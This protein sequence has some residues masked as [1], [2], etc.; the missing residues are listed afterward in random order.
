V[1][2]GTCASIVRSLVDSRILVGLG[3]G[4]LAGGG[5]L[6]LRFGRAPTP[7]VVGLEG[8]M[9]KLEIGFRGVLPM[10]AYFQNG[11]G[12]LVGMCWLGLCAVLGGARRGCTRRGAGVMKE[13]PS[14]WIED[15]S[16]GDSWSWRE[17]YVADD[18]GTGGAPAP[19]CLRARGNGLPSAVD[20][21]AAGT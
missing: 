6:L 3:A 4:D 5:E 14:S 8:L 10:S 7:P 15:V 12:E 2:M 16:V 9:S 21:M 19:A 20:T 17:V 13:P 11:A 18:V 1:G